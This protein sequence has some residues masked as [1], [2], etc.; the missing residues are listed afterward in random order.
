[1]SA[2]NFD[3]SGW[4]TIMPALTTGGVV[5]SNGTMVGLIPMG[6]GPNSRTGNDIFV[7][8]IDIRGQIRHASVTTS[9]DTGALVRIVCIRDRQPNAAAAA[10]DDVFSVVGPIGGVLAFPNLANALRFEILYDRVFNVNPT[11]GLASWPESRIDVVRLL[12]CEFPVRYNNI[13]VGVG[14][15][16]TNNVFLGA[17]L[18]RVSSAA[19]RKSVV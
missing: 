2:R 14:S 16:T 10:F 8:G 4:D 7:R 3:S 1:M 19:D 12:K 11:I 13:A 9:A 5:Q 18:A 6:A 15:V 17:A